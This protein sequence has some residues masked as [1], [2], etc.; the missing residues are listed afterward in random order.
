M[1]SNKAEED[2]GVKAE[3]QEETESSAGED[4]GTSSRVGGADQSVGYIVHFGNAV[5][6]YQR[7]NQNCFRCSS[8]DLL[9]D[10][11]KDL[12][13]TTQKVSLKAKEGI[14]NKGGW[15]PQKPVAAQLA[16]QDEVLR[17]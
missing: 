15:A 1:E 3:E 2:S 12:S 4:A 16:F 6:L 17:A 8:P 14:T 7:K 11:P 5:K 10:C 13:K 9:K